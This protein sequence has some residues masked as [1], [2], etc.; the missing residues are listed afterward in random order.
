MGW[1]KIIYKELQNGHL[2]VNEKSRIIAIEKT[3]HFRKS[4]LREANFEGS[5][6]LAQGAYEF[7]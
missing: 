6:S 1:A 3:V 2:L 7:K 5:L 4:G